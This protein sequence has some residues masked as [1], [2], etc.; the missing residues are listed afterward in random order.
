MP[1][2]SAVEDSTC[3]ADIKQ[4]V[5]AQDVF[6]HGH[7]EMQHKA[8]GHECSCGR[9]V[10]GQGAKVLS[11]STQVFVHHILKDE[12][13]GQKEGQGDQREDGEEEEVSGVVE[14]IRS[15][16]PHNNNNA[17]EAWM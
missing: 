15:N 4:L 12:V 5:H 3:W 7:C 11:G 1:C 17:H 6:D 8:Q 13:D 10:L 16:A 2:E 14:E 9:L